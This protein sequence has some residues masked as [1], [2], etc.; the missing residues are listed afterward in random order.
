[1]PEKI[2]MS[3]VNVWSHV[4]VTVLNSF[5]NALKRCNDYLLFDARE[6]HPKMDFRHEWST[7]ELGLCFE[8]NLV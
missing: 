1:M 5:R 7:S 6:L 4:T 2:G 3:R 8:C